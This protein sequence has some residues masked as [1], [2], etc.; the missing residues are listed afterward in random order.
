[1]EQYLV[2]K[3]RDKVHV[4]AFRPKIAEPKAYCALEHFPGAECRIF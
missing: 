2:S 4:L 1:M 3:G